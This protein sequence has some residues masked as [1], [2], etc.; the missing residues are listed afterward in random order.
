MDQL[1]DPAPFEVVVIPISRYQH[2][3]KLDQVQTEAE[4]IVDLFCELGALPSSP[5][6]TGDVLD[7][8]AVKNLL[9]GWATRTAPS[10]GVLLWLGHG[11]SDGDEAWLASY[12]TPDPINGNGIV[13][14]TI[15]DQ[16]DS[17][18]RRRAA[19]STAWALII[20]EACGAARFVENMAALL[21]K[22]SPRRLALIGVGGDG[23]AYLGR[24][25][26]ALSAAV[27]S[28]TI[29]DEYVGLRDLYNR[30]EDFLVDDYLVPFRIGNELK[31]PHRRLIDISIA[32]P[33]DIYKELIDYLG[34]LPPDQ[35][36]HFI[37]KAQGAEYGEL[38]WYFVG[39]MAWRR[40]IA[41]WLRN[42]PN[43]MLIVTGRAGTGKSALLG[44]IIVYTNPKLRN[45]L[46]QAGQLE[47]EE[48][49]LLPPDNAFDAIIHL[50]GIT[51][52]ELITKLAD[53]AGLTLPTA[54]SAESGQDLEAVLASLRDRQ[55]TIL[56]DALDEAQEP[57]TIAS[58]VLRRLGALPR[59]RV[60]VGTRASTKEGPDQPF[61]TDQDLLEALG[62]GNATSITVERDQDAIAEYVGRRLAFAIEGG[63]AQ[64]VSRIASLA[65]GPGREFLFAR[66][67]VYEVIANPALLSAES[68]EELEVLL[69]Q[70]H[71]TLFAA[72]VARL[73][74]GSR[75]AKPLLEALA[76]ARGRGVPR[77]DRIWAALAGAIAEGEE[78]RETDIDQLLKAAAP[79][80]MLDAEDTQSVY[81]LAHQTF[82]EY[83]LRAEGASL[84]ARHAQVAR[85]LATRSERLSPLNPYV[86]RRLAEH[87]GEAG[88]WEELA[89]NL[90]VLDRLDPESVAAEALRTGYGRA[91]LPLAI[92]AS[93]SARHLLSSVEAPDRW[94]TRQFTMSCLASAGPADA[95]GYA[96]AAAGKPPA[97]WAFMNRHDPLHVLLIG[98]NG[99]IR[100]VTA[101]DLAD[102]RVL[103]AT[104]SDDGTIRLWDPTTGRPIGEPLDTGGEPALTMTPFHSGDGRTLL[105]FG[106]DD[107]RLRMWDPGNGKLYDYPGVGHEGPIFGMIH[108]SMSRWQEMLVTCGFDRTVLGWEMTPGAPVIP[109]L[110]VS[111]R[112]VGA[113][114]VLPVSHGHPLLVTGGYDAQVQLWDAI[115]GEPSGEPLTG[116][117]GV[118]HSL[119]V[120]SLADGRQRVAAAGDDSEIRVWDRPEDSPGRVLA[121]HVGAISAIVALPLPSGTLLA[122]GGEDATVRLWDPDA[123]HGVGEPLTGHRQSVQA[124]APVVLRDGRTLLASGGEDNTVR[125]WNP[126]AAR[127]SFAP[128]R[129]RRPRLR[130]MATATTPE[131]RRILVTGNDEGVIQAWDFTTGAPAGPVMTGEA[132]TIHAIAAVRSPDG[133][134][135]VAANGAGG[136][137]VRWALDPVKPTR[138]GTPIY[139][140]TSTVRTVTPLWLPAGRLGLASAGND[141]KIRLWDLLTGSPA[142]I[143]SGGHRGAISALQP[144]ATPRGTMLASAG[145]DPTVILWDAGTL[146]PVARLRE[147]AM[148]VSFS[149]L[150][151]IPG[152]SSGEAWL[153]AGTRDGQ[154]IVWS[155]EGFRIVRSLPAVGDSV[156]SLA[157]MGLP[158]GRHLL[159]AAYA[160]G[161]IRLWDVV[162]PCLARKVPLPFEQRAQTLITASCAMAVQTDFAVMVS[163]LDPALASP[164]WP[165][166]DNQLVLR[167]GGLRSQGGR[168][169]AN[170]VPL[171]APVEEPAVSRGRLSGLGGASVPLL[172]WLP[173]GSERRLAGAAC[174]LTKSAS[175]P[176]LASSP[177]QR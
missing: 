13:P 136:S 157:A 80:I 106:G 95:A 87:V 72:A 89:D 144:I 47:R 62:H 7:E 5:S 86:K 61:T 78:P 21:L 175:E 102:G 58:T 123:G 81:R 146:T 17:D 133:P 64:A 158:G 156:L 124:L 174:S 159:A 6:N 46:I 140:H 56:T 130:S 108:V 98:H 147:E 82:R 39:R 173:G 25:R 109:R 122:S 104:G 148:A 57:A 11:A 65:S 162:R 10:S 142:G 69:S 53:A 27:A 30:L 66:L 31:L 28:Y 125:I 20:I 19:D 110:L 170:T 44:N 134:T 43:G 155:T 129:Y 4:S 1:S 172:T 120:V 68:R 2:H 79:Y 85:A 12:E 90:A 101:L 137:I 141:N 14:Q 83:F 18:W 135:I 92:A 75:T 105:A 9:R 55:F 153:A 121:G 29:N 132:V 50:T 23:A 54:E 32:A 60:I 163:E 59:V 168:S 70:D 45:L 74:A 36:S 107:G 160:D 49:S 93:L 138:L 8:T 143:L 167:G 152:P 26:A 22:K 52:S 128:S 164:S 149:A 177:S 24:F 97:S 113:V 165:D 94:M 34:E 119:A 51:T 103:L 154:V 63:H 3:P 33:V 35:R 139:G 99:S 76:L 166:G 96:D 161:C 151:V 145:E 77:A 126:M 37:P 127:R 118:I 41:A 42:S 73:S 16:V 112:L 91:N 15:A 48:V 71:R 150:A 171:P 115:T 116:Y 176:C 169:T 111:G 100:A 67:A 38:A 131:G 40:E 117:S 88:T 84:A 114:S